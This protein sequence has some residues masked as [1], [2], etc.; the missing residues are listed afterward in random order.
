MAKG[1]AGRRLGQA[2]DRYA[3]SHHALGG[4]G[5]EVPG[6]VL[7][8]K[9][10]A[11]GTSELGERLGERSEALRKE[12]VAVLPALSL[13][14]PQHAALEIEVAPAEAHDLA[15]PRSGRVHQS[16]EQLVAERGRA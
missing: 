1:V 13:P 10:V 8:F 16:E 7:S 14:N 9:N 6:G 4:S 15:H 3:A 5:R 11:L 2:G 12:Y